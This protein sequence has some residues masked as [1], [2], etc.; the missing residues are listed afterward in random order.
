MPSWLRTSDYCAEPRVSRKLIAVTDPLTGTGRRLPDA[1]HFKFVY[2]AFGKDAGFMQWYMP[3]S[4]PAW[5]EPLANRV[6]YTN[7]FAFTN[8][9]CMQVLYLCLAVISFF[10]LTCQFW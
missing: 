1:H 7:S 6:T 9:Y 3:G 2:R 4:A 10:W 8:L 5:Q